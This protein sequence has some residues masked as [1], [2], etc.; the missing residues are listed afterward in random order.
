MAH[1]RS[2]RNE[3]SPFFSPEPASS[4]V[5]VICLVFLH[6]RVSHRRHRL[7]PTS[8]ST[9]SK[10]SVNACQTS[11]RFR[12]SNDTSRLTWLVGGASRI[13]STRSSSVRYR[14]WSRK[15]TNEASAA[16]ACM[17]DAADVHRDNRCTPGLG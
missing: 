16:P 1:V 3:Y 2:G 8:G 15:T 6:H 7:M 14:P 10:N 17:V 5:L 13:R 11:C 12:Y 9:N 4:L